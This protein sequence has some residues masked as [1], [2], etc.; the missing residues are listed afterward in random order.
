MYHTLGMVCLKKHLAND[1]NTYQGL[2]LIK[3][4]IVSGAFL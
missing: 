3:K 4:V 2:C 1:V